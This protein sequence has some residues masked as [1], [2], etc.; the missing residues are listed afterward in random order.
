LDPPREDAF[1]FQPHR[2]LA[3]YRSLFLQYSPLSNC[4]SPATATTIPTVAIRPVIAMAVYVDTEQVRP[5]APAMRPTPPMKLVIMALVPS[6]P[7]HMIVEPASTFMWTQSQTPRSVRAARTIWSVEGS[8]RTSV[9][10]LHLRF[11]VVWYEHDIAQSAAPWA[12]WPLPQATEDHVA[13]GYNLL[14]RLQHLST[15]LLLAFALILS[16]L[17]T[18]DNFYCDA[19]S[20]LWEVEEDWRFI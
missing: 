15:K 7:R 19:S 20:L 13:N 9:E 3:A 17:Q 16:D 11:A 2:S 1:S 5:A 14:A 6:A 10:T 12:P 8:S 18:S 4:D